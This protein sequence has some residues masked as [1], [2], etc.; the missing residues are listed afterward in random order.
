MSF[1]KSNSILLH[2]QPSQERPNL[3]GVD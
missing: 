3:F 1:M 2:H